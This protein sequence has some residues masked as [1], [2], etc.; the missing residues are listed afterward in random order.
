[1]PSPKTDPHDPLAA[2]SN[3][4]AAGRSTPYGPFPGLQE[5]A[6]GGADNS[7]L[8]N[9]SSDEKAAVAERLRSDGKRPEGDPAGR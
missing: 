7:P 3:A 1:M 6:L 4:D 8:E 9:Q 2:P 5:E